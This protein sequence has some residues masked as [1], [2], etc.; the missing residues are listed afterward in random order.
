MV[1][2]K[3]FYPMEDLFFSWNGEPPVK[4]VHILTQKVNFLF[5]YGKF[6]QIF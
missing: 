1:V 4:T 6:Q 2:S 5:I 3:K